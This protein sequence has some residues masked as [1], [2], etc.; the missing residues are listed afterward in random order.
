MARSR[1]ALTIARATARAWC[2]SP[3]VAMMAARSRSP[4]RA[5]TSAAL[6]P[7][8]PCA[9][10]AVR[11]AG[12]KIRA[13]LRQAAS[14]RRRDRARRRR[15]RRCPRCAARFEKRSST[16]SSR[17]PRLADE[18]GA[19]RDGRLIAVDAD[20][21]RVRRLQDR[22]RIAAA[23]ERRVDIEAAATDAEPV[24]DA[25]GEHGNVAGRSASDSVA[26][27][28]R[29]HSRAPS[30]FAAAIRVPSAF[31]NART[32][33]V[34]SASSARKRLGSQIRNL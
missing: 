31:L 26:A 2:S 19:L 8:R 34:A 30:G 24:D 3:K 22:P 20:H 6:G 28:A 17:P 27:A 4:A 18:S 9:C 21:A 10:R 5:T 7:S 1:R 11:R 14:T 23:A 33:S 15:R 12:T 25:A 29:R 16:S 13:R 32:F